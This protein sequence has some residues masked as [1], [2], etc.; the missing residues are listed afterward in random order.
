MGSDGVIKR[1]RG[2]GCYQ[3]EREHLAEEKGFFLEQMFRRRDDEKSF[4]RPR[5]Q[6]K[7]STW[8][9]ERAIK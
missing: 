1:K 6:K 7:K 8:L 4:H 9:G 5:D 2:T 3:I